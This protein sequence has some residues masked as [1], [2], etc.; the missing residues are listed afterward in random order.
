MI[1]VAGFA[2]ALDGVDAIFHTA[3]YFREYYAP[4][5]HANIIDRINVQATVEL[6]RVAQ[7]RR[8]KRMVHTSSTGIIGLQS[9][10][11]AGN[12]E[13]PPW[14]GAKKNLYFQSKRAVEP[15]LRAFS[16][17]TGLF[18]AFALPAWMWGPHDAAPT[19]SGRLVFD[20]LA[21]KLPPAIPP[22]GSCVVDARDVADGMLR[23]A[24]GG[25]S[26]ERYILSSSYVELED[27]LTN[28][29]LLTGAKPPK[30]KMPFV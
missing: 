18:I 22:G 20:A 5:D 15:L 11:S 3:A 30:V 14:P 1:D 29:A 28:L 25:R 8:V 6:A 10:G 12:E 26:E 19:P 2:D 9:D 27:I 7:S 13:T 16:R 17:E 24:Q 23:I 21:H 4:G